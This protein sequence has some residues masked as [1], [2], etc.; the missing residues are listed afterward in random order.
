MLY[1]HV[2]LFKSPALA[3]IIVWIQVRSHEWWLAYFYFFAV[4]SRALLN[5]SVH[6]SV[7]NNSSM[8]LVWFLPCRMCM[9][10]TF[11]KIAKLIAMKLWIY[12]GAI[13][14][15]HGVCVCVY[16][17]MYVCVRVCVC[18][19][20][21]EADTHAQS[22]RQTDTHHSNT[23]ISSLYKNRKSVSTP[24]SRWRLMEELWNE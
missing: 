13:A 5:S 7:H 4:I 15:L 18:V 10:S 22:D 24:C 8:V 12:N 17:C 3:N 6:G 9:L 20:E 2:N 21:R 23:L 1:Y 11:F 16:V 19:R 14:Y